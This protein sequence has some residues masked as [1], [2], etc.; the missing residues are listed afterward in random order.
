MKNENETMRIIFFAYFL[1][2][3]MLPAYGFSDKKPF[4]VPRSTVH[5]IHSKI[6]GRSYDLYVKLPFGYFK[7]KNASRQYPAMY[8]N[9]GIYTFQV[10]SGVQAVEK[11]NFPE[12]K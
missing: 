7:T 1:I 11:S 4:E 2:I 3:P 12:P 10:A 5:T 6:L 8:L 9:D